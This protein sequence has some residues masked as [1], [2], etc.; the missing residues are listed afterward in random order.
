VSDP[1]PSSAD[2]DATLLE[3]LRGTDYPPVELRPFACI[4]P[5]A[6]G[7]WQPMPEEDGQMLPGAISATLHQIVERDGSLYDVV[8]W[9]TAGNGS[10]WWL[11]Y[12][13]AT[14]LGE[15]DIE[16]ANILHKPVRLVPTP[17]AFVKHRLCCCIL[18]WKADVR[19]ILGLAQYGWLCTSP[20]LARRAQTVMRERHLAKIQLVA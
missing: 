18:N 11:R 9:E 14:F 8:A 15:R 16:L 17:R 19:A 12:D 1:I 4:L 7:T 5:S 3:W 6:D 2:E 10:P 13:R 20:A